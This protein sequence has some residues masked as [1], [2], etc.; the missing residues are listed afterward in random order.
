MADLPIL[1]TA[2]HVMK[3]TQG[4]QPPAQPP[5]HPTH[6]P[7]AQAL[8]HGREAVGLLGRHHRRPAPRRH[9]QRFA[10]AR[11][12]AGVVDNEQCMAEE[13]TVTWKQQRRQQQSSTNC[14]RR[15]LLGAHL[16]GCTTSELIWSLDTYAYP[17]CTRAAAGACRHVAVGRL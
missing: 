2:V 13:M 17:A 12:A 5:L 15:W 1:P 9:H 10:Q 16:K 3:L 7:L 4:V 14:E 11:P 8:H 6:A